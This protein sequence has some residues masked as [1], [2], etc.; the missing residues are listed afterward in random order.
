MNIGQSR[1]NR[2]PPGFIP[3]ASACAAL[4]TFVLMFVDSHCHINFPELRSR[5]PEV[6]AAMQATQPLSVVMRERIEQLRAWARNRCVP[7][8]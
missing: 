6:L 7:A 4:S 8:D 2:T 3:K 5:L 1:E